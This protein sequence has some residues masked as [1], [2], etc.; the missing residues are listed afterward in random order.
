MWLKPTAR[1][2][3]GGELIK[4]KWCSSL[5]IKDSHSVFRVL[6]NFIFSNFVKVSGNPFVQPSILFLLRTHGSGAVRRAY[7]RLRKRFPTAHPGATTAVC[8]F[9]ATPLPASEINRPLILHFVRAV[10]KVTYFY[11]LTPC[12]SQGIC[13]NSFKTLRFGGC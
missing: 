12:P 10:H 11:T 1:Q 9:S 6:I 2:P 7:I 3:K 13:G 5:K 4:K 8:F